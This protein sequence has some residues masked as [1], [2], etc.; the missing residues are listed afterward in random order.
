MSFTSKPVIAYDKNKP[1]CIFFLYWNVF[2]VETA[3]KWKQNDS[4]FK[5]NDFHEI[6]L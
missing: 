3:T 6:V 1:D 2:Y 4:I 5:S